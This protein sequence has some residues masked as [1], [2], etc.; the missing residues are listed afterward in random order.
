MEDMETQGLCGSKLHINS[1]EVTK[2]KKVW[3]IAYFIRVLILNSLP[4]VL[5]ILTAVGRWTGLG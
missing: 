4:R 5:A 1:L 2:N 3:L